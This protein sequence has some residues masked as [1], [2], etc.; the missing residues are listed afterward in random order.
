MDVPKRDQVQNLPLHLPPFYKT[1]PRTFVICLCGTGDAEDF[2]DCPGELRFGKELEDE[3]MIILFPI[4]VDP[5][6]QENWK[7]VLLIS[8]DNVCK[9]LCKAS[10]NHST[11]NIYV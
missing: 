4:F 10:S 11:L 1:F 7:V 2:C 9:K 8:N 3:G 5:L 6:T